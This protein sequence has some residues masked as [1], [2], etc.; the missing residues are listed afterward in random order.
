MSCRYPFDVFDRLWGPSYN[1]KWTQLTTSNTVNPGRN[2]QPPSEV[3]GTAATPP[4]ANSPL[5]FFWSATDPKT[6]FYVYMYFSEL[7]QLKPNESR[8]FSINLNGDLLYGPLIPEYLNVTTIYTPRGLDGGNFSF[9]IFRL[10]NSTLPSIL[11]AIEAYMLVDFSQL[12][13]EQNDG[14][15]VFFPSYRLI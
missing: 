1:S 2:Y 4:D 8:A 10:E 3:M 9:S 7:E 14:T 5:E 12:E 11:N 13:T 6:K 15:H